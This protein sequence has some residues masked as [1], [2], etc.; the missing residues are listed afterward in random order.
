MG[1]EKIPKNPHVDEVEMLNQIWNNNIPKMRGVVSVSVDNNFSTE[2]STQKKVE[3][4][5]YD[6]FADI[7]SAMPVFKRSK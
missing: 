3:T 1:T 4:K 7:F 6:M 5:P 2:W